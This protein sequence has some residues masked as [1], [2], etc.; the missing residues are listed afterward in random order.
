MNDQKIELLWNALQFYREQGIPE[1]T[2]E[3]DEEW[4]DICTAMWQLMEE[5]GMPTGVEYYGD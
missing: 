4:N 5:A 1:G 2:A 3:Y